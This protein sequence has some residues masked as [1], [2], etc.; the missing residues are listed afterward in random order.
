M[1]KEFFPQG[2]GCVFQHSFGQIP[3]PPAPGQPPQAGTIPKEDTLPGQ[4]PPG[5]TPPRQTSP[6]QTPPVPNTTG[7]GQQAGGTHPTGMHTCFMNILVQGHRK[8]CWVP[9]CQFEETLRLEEQCRREENSLAPPCGG[10]R[11]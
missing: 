6:G 7:Y 9:P 10:N 1:C 8:S 3:P 5:E 11:N 4:T 2:A